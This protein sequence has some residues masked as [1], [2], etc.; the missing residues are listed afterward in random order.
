ME[1]IGNS[2][3][4]AFLQVQDTIHSVGSKAN[5]VSAIDMILPFLMSLA[6][7]T[8]GSIVV[9]FGA[10]AILSRV[11]NSRIVVGQFV[12]NI[13]GVKTTTTT[14]LYAGVAKRFDFNKYSDAVEAHRLEQEYIS[15]FQKGA[16]SIYSGLVS[17]HVKNIL[18]GRNKIPVVSS[19][20]SIVDSALSYSVYQ[21]LITNNIFDELQNYIT[22]DNSNERNFYHEVENKLLNL[23]VPI[24]VNNTEISL[25]EIK[26][27]FILYF[28]E[29]IWSMVFFGDNPRKKLGKKGV[30]ND[31][32]IVYFDDL[33]KNKEFTHYLLRKFSRSKEFY[34]TKY[35]SDY[36]IASQINFMVE[37]FREIAKKIK[38]KEKYFGPSVIELK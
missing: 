21:K 8:L 15:I 10:K 14:Q 16:S 25:E 36:H 26:N 38:N 5:T 6:V 29:L 30:G 20:V 1:T 12:S 17:G 37:K 35:S 33:K 7:D 18:S 3:L 24:K 22:V 4:V 19:T 27:E 11:A 2:A 34:S 31:S 28:E 13:P 23:Y 9:K 32:H